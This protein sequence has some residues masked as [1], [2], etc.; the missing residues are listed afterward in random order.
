MYE[1]VGS[2][3]EGKEY[4]LFCSL[5]SQVRCRRATG[6]NGWQLSVTEKCTLELVEM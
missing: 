2:H 4:A 1:L 3:L 6:G 5:P